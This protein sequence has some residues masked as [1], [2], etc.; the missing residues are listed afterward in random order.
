MKNNYEFWKNKLAAFMHDTPSKS[1][2]ISS[3]W[4]KSKKAM[5]RAGFLD[6]E[7]G[8]YDLQADHIASA[9]DRFCGGI[10]GGGG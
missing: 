5:S 2:D 1:L 9:A 3:H 7:I 8:K 6:E 4:D 10:G